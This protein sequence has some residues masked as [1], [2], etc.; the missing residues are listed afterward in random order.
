M[1]APQ[2]PDEGRSEARGVG[3]RLR[4]LRK[5]KGLTGS[6][7]AGKVGVS[8]S[9]ISRIETGVV[10]PDPDEVEHI[11]LALGENPAV[12][13]RLR[14]LVEQPVAMTQFVLGVDQDLYRDYERQATTIRLFQPAVVPGLLQTS[15]Y[16][17][18]LFVGYANL[19]GRSYAEGGAQALADRMER[20]LSLY[21]DKTFVFVLLEAVFTQPIASPTVMLTQIETLEQL[22]DLRNVTVRIV[23]SGQRLLVPALGSIEIFD[24]ERALVETYVG[25]VPQTD[26]EDVTVLRRLFDH[27]EALATDDIG[28]ILRKYRRNYAQPIADEVRP[29]TAESGTADSSAD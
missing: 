16:A 21:T 7:L 5:A 28:P 14:G 25:T 3:P 19:L 18:A 1:N 10:V 8:Q 20:Q 13:A 2:P 29:V 11:V 17:K 24:D 27:F 4:R 12:A 6:Q 9:K 26:P 15:A 23:P 22:A